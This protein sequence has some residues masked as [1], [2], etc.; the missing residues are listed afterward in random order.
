VPLENVGDCAKCHTCDAWRLVRGVKERHEQAGFPLVGAHA[1]TACASCHR[2]GRTFP[3][4]VAA[5]CTACHVS[6][7][8][9]DLGPSCTACHKSDD[10]EWNDAARSR[11]PVSAHA[12]T[13]F[14]LT[15]PHAGHDCAACH[16]PTVR[17]Y[18]KRFPGRQPDRCDA[19]HSDPH[20]GQFR[21]R[22]G[23]C[24]AC[25]PG[26]RTSFV[27]A[28]YSIADHRTFPLAGGHLAVPCIRCH[29]PDAQTGVRRFVGTARR[30]RDCHVNPHGE[31]FRREISANGCRA[32]HTSLATWRFDRN[33]FD[34]AATGYP[35]EGAHAR[36]ACGDCHVR[37]ASTAPVR[38]RGTPTDCRGC[39]VDPHRGQLT[40]AGGAGCTRCHVST[41]AWRD[42]RFD[43]Q[44]HA[45]FKLDGV[46]RRLDCA[47]CHV[48]RK[49][50]GGASTIHYRPLGRDCK[51]CHAVKR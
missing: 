28:R 45:R 33:S 37:P 7:H 17:V 11:F 27:P 6:P 1:S 47:A 12:G 9:T 44:R 48:K 3:K 43:H 50:P 20:R 24:V 46:H 4:N 15:P 19:C 40:P 51:D 34:H 26:N 21:S 18:A 13:G 32:C 35:L 5:D 2:P 38:Y 23:G 30:C 16:R 8:R 31:Q 42:H 36:A 25:H 39:H 10:P 14:P 29:Q 41:T 49:L 22:P